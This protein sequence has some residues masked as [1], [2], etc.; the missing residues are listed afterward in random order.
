M[1]PNHAETILAKLHDQCASGVDCDVIFRAI[2]HLRLNGSPDT[3]ADSSEDNAWI[4]LHCHKNV[5]RAAS[6]F[7]DGIFSKKFTEGVQIEEGIEAKLVENDEKRQ[8]VQVTFHKISS[9]SLQAFVEFAYTGSVK[10]DT[11]VL[12]K[13]VEDLK[14]MNMHSMLEELSRSNDDLSSSNAIFKLVMSFSLQLDDPYRKVMSF[15]LHE[16]CHGLMRDKGFGET[17]TRIIDEQ[18][19]CCETSGKISSTLKEEAEIIE[20]LGLTEDHGLILILTKLVRTN[21]ISKEDELK[22]LNFLITKRREKCN[23]HFEKIILY[24]L[25]DDE[26]LCLKCLHKSCHAK[27]HVEPVDEVKCDQLAPF[28]QRTDMELDNIKQGSKDRL[29]AL[30]ELENIIMEE[31][32]HNLAIQDSCSQIKPKMDNLAKIFKS[33]KI[34]PNNS[35]ALAFQ[36]FVAAMKKES[37]SLKNE[38]QRAKKVSDELLVLMEKRIASCAYIVDDAL[39]IVTL[40]EDFEEIDL[41]GPLNSNSCSSILQR[42]KKKNNKEAYDRAFDFIVGNFMCVVDESGTSFHRR[43]GPNVLEDLLKSD[44]LKI[45]SEDDIILVVKEWIH[46]DIRQRKK[47]ASKL[48]KLIRFGELSK[49]MLEKFDDDPSFLVLLDE[50]LKLMLSDAVAGKCVRNPRDFT[51]SKLLALG[52]NGNNLLY[53]SVNCSWEE[54]NSQ[55]SIRFFGA[56][57]VSKNV[58]IIGGRGANTRLSKVSIYNSE[59]KTWRDGPSL[60]ETRCSFGVCVDSKNTIY[61]LGG[62]NNEG[63]IINS[64]ELLNCDRNGEP[65]GDWQI[66]TSMIKKRYLFEAAIIDDKVYAVGGYSGGSLKDMEVFDKLNVWKECPMSKARDG[67]A[68]VT[69]NEE[70]YVF[71]EDGVCEKYN[72]VTDTWTAIAACPN[73]ARYRGSAVLNGKIYLVGGLGCEETNIYDPKANK[74]SKGRQMPREIG[75][76]KCVTWK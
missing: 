70:I 34:L 47:Y 2:D 33:G 4:S 46:F 60:R 59:T 15:I 27:H 11:T 16:F 24:C 21:C 36:Q 67:H 8:I 73:K 57:K 22:L 13:V 45:E 52:E 26:Q 68:V 25:T 71:D 58:Y 41:N 17:L 40:E 10:L 54:W 76:T 30:K 61:V 69:F 64:A 7:F 51:V 23:I 50:Q 65:T 74:W 1:T 5:I 3:T 72:P 49:E 12:K 14:I 66:L 42:A 19:P 62:L 18:L 6:S 9:H 44:N 31:R 39:E 48:L 63:Y 37:L 38:Y 75:A 35:D 32:I 28:W 53:N 56:V 20:K 29:T 43:I 55:D